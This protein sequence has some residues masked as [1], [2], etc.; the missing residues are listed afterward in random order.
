MK[1]YHYTTGSN[2]P[3]ILHDGLIKLEGQAGQIQH[4]PAWVFDQKLMPCFA[5]FTRADTFP[6]T[7]LPTIVG[8]DGVPVIDPDLLVAC[9]V[10]CGF[11]RIEVDTEQAGLI[12]WSKHPWR[13][14]NLLAR[15][16]KVF[17]KIAAVKGDNPLDWWVAEH[18]VLITEAA[19]EPYWPASI[20]K[21]LEDRKV[22][23]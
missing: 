23:A 2:L 9:S 19:V 12:R 20:L 14:K 7:A 22:S 15:N 1:V 21:A 8:Q 3:N 17:E 5:W 6:A 4:L 13:R 16:L 18:P 10:A 11:F